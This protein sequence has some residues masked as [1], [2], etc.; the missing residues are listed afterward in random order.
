MAIQGARELAAELAS[1]RKG[2]TRPLYLVHGTE[3]YLVRTSADA[4]ASSLAEAMGAERIT[5]DA[6]GQSAEAVLSP[7]TSLSLF[8]SAQVV[9]VKNF[10]HLLTGDA[11]DRL[12]AGLDSVSGEGNALVFTAGG[13]GPGEKLDKRVKGYK[14]LVKRAAVVEL[15]TQKPED[16]LLWLKE[17][18]REEGKT[19][20]PDAAQLLLMRTGPDMETLR[21]ELD[22]AVLYHLEEKRITADSLA[23]LVGKTREDAVWDVSE[24]IAAGDAPGA[25]NLLEDLFV[26]GTYPLVVLTLLVR[27]TRHMLQ[28]RLLWERAGCPPFGDPRSFQGRVNPE[29]GAFGG[30]ADDVTTIHPFASFKRFEAARDHDVPEL[31]QLLSRLR[32]AD[33]EAKT[34]VGA[35]ARETVE[36]LVLDLCAAAVPGRSAA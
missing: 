21:M 30:G 14:G 6:A 18:A 35:G 3:G 7:V 24:R 32:R 19:L 34:G 31:R 4:I 23:R 11:A 36:Q 15:N 27:Q 1:I 28:A 2:K 26:A 8:A 20:D 13:T 33:R 25:L 16:L 17:K 22:K 5:Q 9:V 29:K 12:L 10:S